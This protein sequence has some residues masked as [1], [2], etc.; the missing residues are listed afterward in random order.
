MLY[1]L[2]TETRSVLSLNGIW[3]FK[4]QADGERHDPVAPLQTTE[5]MAV[6]ASFNDQTANPELR[7]HSGYFWYERDFTVPA[8]L[9]DQRLSLRFGSATH[10]AWV[11]VNG[12]AVGHHKG[13]FTPF[14]L[15]I[16]DAIQAG[17]NRLTVKISNLLDHSTLPVG[18]YTE[19][20]DANGNT[21]AH[22][23][24]NFDFFNYAGLHRN[25]N[26]LSTPWN[27][28]EDITVTPHI[29]LATTSADIDVAV[30]TTAAATVKVTL[31]D[32]EGTVVATTNG[33]I[34]R[35]IWT[36]STSGNR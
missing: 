27:R 8:A 6:P 17:T 7:Q 36:T 15:P 14:E 31:L 24:E 26:L 19:T 4:M 25:V 16:N 30:K 13:G 1:P 34:A 29:D 32:E 10:E 20:K 22:V 11:F 18:N 3:S 33:A 9:M 2:M 35:F 12:T 23:D 5:V 28:V 21:V